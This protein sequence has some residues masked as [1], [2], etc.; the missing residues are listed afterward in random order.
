MLTV[1]DVHLVFVAQPVL[2][3]YA[4]EG[5]EKNMTVAELIEYYHH[6]REYA[7]QTGR[8]GRYQHTNSIVHS[9]TSHQQIKSVG[10]GEISNSPKNGQIV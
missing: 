1:S 5:F 9:L 8:S 3:L 2:D 7:V 4:Q 6:S 10:M